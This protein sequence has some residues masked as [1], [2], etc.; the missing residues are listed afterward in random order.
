METW[1]GIDSSPLEERN[2]QRRR[3]WSCSG[4]TVARMCREK[5]TVQHLNLPWEL[6]VVLIPAP[7][8]S[9][10][11][12]PPDPDSDPVHAPLL[13]SPYERSHQA[14]PFQPQTASVPQEPRCSRASAK[15]S[16]S[17]TLLQGNGIILDVPEN[18]K[19][20]TL[21][22]LQCGTAHVGKYSH[23]NALQITIN[24][25]D[26]GICR[27]LATIVMVSFD[28]PATLSREPGH[29]VAGFHVDHPFLKFEHG[30]WQIWMV[31]CLGSVLENSCGC[32]QSG[33]PED[34]GHW[35]AVR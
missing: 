22:L 5:C 33:C 17:D 31:V 9:H 15:L 7:T 35:N 24:G 12:S 14:S 6:S 20:R 1:D 18:F 23:R 2:L 10:V 27:A 13:S 16:A 3:N 8:F 28:E 26:S 25:I 21:S 19:Q 4:N 29:S 30:G 11:P 32:W 34:D